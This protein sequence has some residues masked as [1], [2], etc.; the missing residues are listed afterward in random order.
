MTSDSYFVLLGKHRAA[1]RFS[2]EECF[3]TLAKEYD[4]YLVRPTITFSHVMVDGDQAFLRG[5]GTGGEGR[6]GSYTQPYYGYWFRVVEEGYA[7]IIEFNDPTELETKLYGKKLVPA[8][9]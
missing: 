2:K 8:E 9:S 6:Y 3:T 1:G 5:S 7:E 4:N